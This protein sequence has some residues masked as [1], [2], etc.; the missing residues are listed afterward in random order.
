MTK[1]LLTVFAAI[2]AATGA[3]SA[4]AQALP[5]TKIAVVD[6]D[7]I[8]RDCTACKA[9]N[10]Q[11]QAQSTQLRSSAQSLSA[12][13][14]T[15]EQSLRTAVTAAKGNPDA[16]LQA[17]ITAFETK[18]NAAQQQIQ[19]QQQTLER[20]V[21]YVRQQIGQKLGPI[22]SQVAQ[23]RGATIAMD[24]GSVFYSAPTVEV[25]D[26]VM[27]QLNTQLPSVSTTAPAQATPAT[28]AA[29]KP[30]GR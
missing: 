13:L 26:A 15:E 3:G 5:D 7:R 27:A 10:T 20:N 21:A 4:F 22:I 9:A 2:A 6:S 28:P 23:Q 12:P 24:K 16:A 30:Q 8:F 25:T 18:R 14:Q 19:T 1:H 17:R 29:A 11:L